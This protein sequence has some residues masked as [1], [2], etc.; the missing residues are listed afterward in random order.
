MESYCLNPLN[1]EPDILA[2]DR[3]D[4]RCCDVM[5]GVLGPAN[6]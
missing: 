3:D 6:S 5:C 2:K 4:A 1:E